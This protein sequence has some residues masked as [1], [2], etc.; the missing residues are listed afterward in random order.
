MEPDVVAEVLGQYIRTLQCYVICHDW[1]GWAKVGTYQEWLFRIDL[2]MLAKELTWSSQMFLDM[3][4]GHQ[5]YH[6]ARH[7]NTSFTVD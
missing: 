7:P 4:P 5:A 2:D 6:D 1:T 3:S